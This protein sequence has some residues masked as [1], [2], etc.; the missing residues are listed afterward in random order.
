MFVYKANSTAGQ[1]HAD[2]MQL[3]LHYL[4]RLCYR[5]H[6]LVIWANRARFIEFVLPAEKNPSLGSKHTVCP[7]IHHYV[8]LDT[9][10]DD[11]NCK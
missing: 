8:F 6:M 3:P 2:T 7:H 1:K 11:Y 5:G 4:E 10:D 9:Y